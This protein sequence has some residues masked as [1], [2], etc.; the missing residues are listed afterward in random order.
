MASSRFHNMDWLTCAFLQ[1]SLMKLKWDVYASVLAQEEDVLSSFHS[2][3]F[4]IH[5]YYLHV[6]LFTQMYLHFYSYVFYYDNAR[7]DLMAQTREEPKNPNLFL[8]YKTLFTPALGFSTRTSNRGN[9]WRLP[10]WFSLEYE[11]MEF[12]RH[13]ARGILDSEL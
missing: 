2:I 12:S 10:Q 5:L 1:F 3:L 7:R 9:N 6:L 8:N 4:I 11:H 13:D